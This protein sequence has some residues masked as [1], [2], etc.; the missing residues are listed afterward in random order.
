M[1]FFSKQSYSNVSI[2]CHFSSKVT[3]N[4][5]TK[6]MACIDERIDLVVECFTPSRGSGLEVI[7]LLS[8]STQM[9]MK[10]Q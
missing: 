10:F 8:C 4:A 3:I 7:K 1:C 5:S 9:S 6:N 2:C